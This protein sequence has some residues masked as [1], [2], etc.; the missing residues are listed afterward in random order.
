RLIAEDFCFGRVRQNADW[1]LLLRRKKESSFH[2]SLRPDFR[3]IG[4]G[5]DHEGGE[6]LRSALH[7]SVNEHYWD[8]NCDS[9]NTLDIRDVAFG[10][11]GYSQSGHGIWLAVF[12][13]LAGD[14]EHGAHSQLFYL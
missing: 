6:S 3:Y 13:E 8:A 11:G 10:E 9:G 1:K 7:V 12:V 4:F 5:G 2:V 14:Y